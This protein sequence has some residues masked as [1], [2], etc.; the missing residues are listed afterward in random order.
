MAKRQR[1]ANKAHQVEDAYKTVAS[2]HQMAVRVT[3][4]RLELETY[5]QMSATRRVGVLQEVVQP[6]IQALIKANAS[7]GMTKDNKSFFLSYFTWWSNYVARIQS[8]LKIN[9]VESSAA[10]CMSQAIDGAV[11]DQSYL[12]LGLELVRVSVQYITT[13]AVTALPR[14]FAWRNSCVWIPTCAPAATKVSG[15]N[16]L[17]CRVRN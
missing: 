16:P 5:N 17:R 3:K 11:K 2:R 12:R 6:V 10:S 7:T 8:E 14:R 13:H 1:I 4:L 15:S 9:D